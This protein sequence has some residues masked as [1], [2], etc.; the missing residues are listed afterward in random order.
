ML[1][2]LSSLSLTVHFAIILGLSVAFGAVVEFVGTD[3]IGMGEF[4]PVISAKAERETSTQKKTTLQTEVAAL[5]AFE[6]EVNQK[7]LD[8]KNAEAA[9][10]RTRVQ[11]PTEKLTDDFLRLL[12]SSTFKAQVSL[13]SFQ[14]QQV[15]FKDFYAEMPFRVTLDGPYFNLKDYFEYLSATDRIINVGSLD[16][17][18]LDPTKKTQGLNYVPDTSV[19]GK[20]TVTTYYIPSEEEL[21]ANA[22]P[23]PGG[24]PGRPGAR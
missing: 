11:V 17:A 7:E 13:R 3:A 19:T 5:E 6:A 10:A 1:D 9:L 4:N 20:C 8:L 21:A 15:V 23:T 14:T 24:R 2:R 16:L 12:E 22:P 18:G